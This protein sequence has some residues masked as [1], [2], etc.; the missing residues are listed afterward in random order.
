LEGRTGE[1]MKE[2]VV[3]S[4]KGGTGKTSIVASFAAL[5]ESKVVADCDVDAADLHLVLRPRFSRWRS[6]HGGKAAVVTLTDAD[7]CGAG[8]AVCRFGAFREEVDPS[9]PTRT[10]WSVDPAVCEGCGACVVACPPGAVLLV[11]VTTGSWAVSRSR[12]GP[13]VHAR[14]AAGR[15]NSGKL[16]TI[17]RSQARDLARHEGVSLVLVDGSP[18]IGCPVIASLTGSDLALLVAEPTVS[19]LHDLK[20]VAA[21]AEKLGVAAVVAV[22]KYDINPDATGRI[23]D[24][25][26]E[27]DVPVAGLIPYDEAVTQAQIAGLTVVEHSD[28]PAASAIADLW[29]AV[30]RTLGLEGGAATAS[31]GH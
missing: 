31:A 18:G 26:V 15:E 10:L 7:E 16:V 13:L 9:D 24:W 22:N 25:C 2:L 12:L 19:G 27:A 29:R 20:R 4:G 6:F 3:L 11:D 5:F 1:L 21:V 30:H 8:A 23:E 14:L 28:G 17:V